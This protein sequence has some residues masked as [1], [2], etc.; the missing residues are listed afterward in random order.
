M[1][2]TT[3]QYLDYVKILFTFKMSQ[4]A[5][6]CNFSYIHKK[7]KAFPGPQMFNFIMYTK[8]HP[9]QMIN[10]ENMERNSFM[11]SSKVWLSLTQFSQNP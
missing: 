6:K 7:G 11:P 9:N 5:S 3:T 2:Y 4:N 1:V 10:V 8:L